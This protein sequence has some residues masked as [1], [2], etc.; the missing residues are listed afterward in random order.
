MASQT[1]GSEDWGKSQFVSWILQHLG[2]YRAAR[3]GQKQGAY[4]ISETPLA[5][6]LTYLL[7]L[8]F[9]AVQRLEIK[10]RWK[11]KGKVGG[12]RAQFETLHWFSGRM[13]W[14]QVAPRFSAS[15]KTQ[16]ELFTGACGMLPLASSMIWDIPRQDLTLSHQKQMYLSTSLVFWRISYSQAWS[17]FQLPMWPTGSSSV[18]DRPNDE[19]AY[20]PHWLIS[21]T[22]FVLLSVWIDTG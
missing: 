17:T 22:C 20:N 3:V 13:G 8:V 1:F 18:F 9:I 15:Y 16:Y 4:S 21:Q 19:S 7:Y 14:S 6:P 10:K 11:E 12:N 2:I 5:I